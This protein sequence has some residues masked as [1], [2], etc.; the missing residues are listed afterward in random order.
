MST[1]VYKLQDY[2]D[3]VFSENLCNYELPENTIRIIKELDGLFK[4][5]LHN[6][7]TSISSQLQSQFNVYDKSKKKKR[8]Y[9]DSWGKDK[10]IPMPVKE[11]KSEFD[12]SISTIRS[13]MNKL[14]ENNFGNTC[15]KIIAILE[16]Y[17]ENMD[18]YDK[19]ITILITISGNNQF[20]SEI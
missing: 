1:L 20:F 12:E 9:G 7:S 15:D 14:S 11:I 19:V 5:K 17:K 16:S 3:I 18:K 6:N 8:D 4:G 2:E 13:L 10:N